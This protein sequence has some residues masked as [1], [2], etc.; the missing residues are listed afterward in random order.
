MSGRGAY[1][2]LA[3]LVVAGCG[4]HGTGAGP[5]CGP[6]MPGA[7]PSSPALGIDRLALPQGSE[8]VLAPVRL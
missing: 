6:A 5:T 1:I 4:A 2:A 8:L 3:C 7:R